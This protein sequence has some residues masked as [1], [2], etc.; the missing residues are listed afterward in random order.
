MLTSEEGPESDEPESS[1]GM[2]KIILLNSV[3]LS[4][5]LLKPVWE[6]GPWHRVHFQHGHPGECV[7]VE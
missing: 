5:S 3:V 4:L 2:A 6:I 7:G 1:L